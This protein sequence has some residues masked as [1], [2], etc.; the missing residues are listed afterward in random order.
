MTRKRSPFR[1]RDHPTPKTEMAEVVAGPVG[2]VDY[3]AVGLATAAGSSGNPRG[4]GK[5][6]CYPSPHLQLLAFSESAGGSLWDGG[7][8]AVRAQARPIHRMSAADGRPGAVHRSHR[9]AHHS[10]SLAACWALV[11]QASRTQICPAVDSDFIATIVEGSSA[12]AG[13]SSSTP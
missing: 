6:S 7:A 5:R 11:R 8:C 9:P 12:T 4:C 2:G 10:R 13:V 3:R 1:A